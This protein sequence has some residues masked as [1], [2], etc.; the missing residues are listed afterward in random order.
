M[1]ADAPALDPD[2]ELR[3]GRSESGVPYIAAV[4]TIDGQEY[5]CPE[6]LSDWQINCFNFAAR[7]AK[8]EYA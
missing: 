7:R 1:P 6:W 3:C 4:I 8:K 2:I 5:F